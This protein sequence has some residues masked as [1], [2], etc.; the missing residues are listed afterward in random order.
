MFFSA[1]KKEPI[2]ER[3][4]SICNVV[5]DREPMNKKE[6]EKILV[7]EKLKVET[8]YF[9]SV[10]E[11]AEE[12][13][14]IGYDDNDDVIFIGDKNNI[15]SLQALRR[16]CNSFVFYDRSTDFYKIISC[17]LSADDEWLAYGRVTTSPEIIRIINNETGIKSLSLEKDV[18]LGIRFWINYLGFGYYQESQGVF[19]PNMYTALRD[20]MVLGSIEEKEYTVEEFIG[21]LHEGVSVALKGSND[22]LKLNLAM[23]NALRLMHDNKEIELKRI[24]DSEKVWHLFPNEEH[25]F[26]SEITHIAIKKA[27]E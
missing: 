2:P 5:V 7:P 14:L 27:V 20:F 24:S 18:L 10:F 26:T 22:T 3:I 17:F 23:S 13:K 21:H 11:T 1:I 16:Y 4:F 19:L 8:S 6:I 12:L 15:E 25:E 9:G